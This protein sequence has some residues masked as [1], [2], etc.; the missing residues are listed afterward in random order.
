MAD[1]APPPSGLSALSGLWPMRAAQSAAEYGI[2]AWQ[3]TV[4]TMDVLRERG[5]QYLEHTKSGKPPVLVFDYDMVLDAREFQKPANYAL[6]RIRPDASHARTDPNKRPFVVI[7]PRAGHGPGIGGF[8][9]DSE[10]GIALQHGHPCYFVMFF[11]I[12]MPGQTIESVCAAEIAFMRKVNELHAEADGK[13][14]VIGNCQGGWALIM[15]AALAPQEVGPILLAGSPVSYWA[16]VEGKNPMRYSGGLMGGTWLAS[17]AGDLGHGKFDGAHLVSNFEGLNPSNTYWSKLYNLYSQV[18]TERERFLEF[19]KWWGGLFLMN[20][21][22]MEWITKNLFVGNKLSAGEVESFDGKHRV[23]IRNIRT[24]IVVFASWG[25]NITPPQ[26]ALNWIPDVYASV[27]EIRLNEQTIVYCLHEKIGHLGIFVS[28]GVAKRETSELASALDL[29]ETLP[30]GLYEAVIQDT[31]PDMPG[32]AYLEGRYLIQFVPRTLDDILAFDDG[33]KDE[34]AFEVVDRVA[35]INQGLYDTFGSP[36][37]KAMTS[38]AS[39][40]ATR[41]TNPARMERWGLSNLNPWMFWVQALAENVRAN[42]RPA[43]P[44]NPFTQ[45]E[46]EVSGRIEQSLDRV[47]DARDE[48]SERMF[49][50]IYEAP[51]LAAAVG[52]GTDALGRRG[53]KSATW[54]QDELK[55]LKRQEIESQF[56]TGTPVDAWARLLLYVR[57][58]ENVVDER[59]FNLMRRMI[60][61]IEPEHRPTLA[62]I[63]SA[64]KRQAFVVALDEERAIA[65]LPR[66][67]PEMHQRR[68][69]FEAARKVASARGKP[70]PHQEERFRRVAAILSLDAPVRPR[71]AA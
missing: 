18:D 53:P 7:D 13:P 45:A 24:P 26:Q 33:R 28:A 21:E 68:K 30:P 31:Q 51:W 17:L 11:P 5:N 14:F 4:L 23:D 22:E 63:K 27:D 37:V 29:I 54:E 49:K 44:D 58:E 8:K 59:P 2:D 41:A 12:P 66:L 10:I 42:R 39:A 60:D 38:E 35:Q 20:K 55:R 43:A 47:R 65:A 34:Q 15:L 3:R 52:L 62:A 6:V 40:E 69:G 16:G 19:E 36:L 67:V 46:R 1:K 70:T 71:R 56:E 50:A 61:E 48:M 25:D 57:R 9:M 64:M 32:L